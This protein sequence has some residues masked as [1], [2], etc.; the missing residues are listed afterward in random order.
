MDLV[1]PIVAGAL[2]GLLSGAPYVVG[3]SV[4]KKRR[5]AS[6]LPALVAVCVSFVV[7][8]LSILIAWAV[9]RDAVLVFAIAMLVVFL[10]TAVASVVMYN[11]KP[12][13]DR[14]RS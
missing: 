13:P 6:I 1:A 2:C 11:R 14:V 12:R 3:L 4:A 7:I 5:D 9:L 8:S 10:L